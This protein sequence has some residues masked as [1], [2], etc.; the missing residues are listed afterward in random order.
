MSGIKS[1]RVP[2]VPQYHYTFIS[3][4]D[5][6]ELDRVYKLIDRHSGRHEIKVLKKYNLT[7]IKFTTPR[8]VNRQT[9][10]SLGRH[11][12]RVSE[13]VTFIPLERET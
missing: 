5:N 7:S 2:L 1:L 6:S 13:N 11:G 10:L 12:I 4:S 9:I 3:P 8:K